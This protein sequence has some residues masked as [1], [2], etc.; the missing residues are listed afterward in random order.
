MSTEHLIDRPAYAGRCPSCRAAV[1]IA[2]DGGLDVTTEIIPASVNAEITAWL[3]RRYAW[4]IIRDPDTRQ[5]R[6]R[7]RGLARIKA[8]RSHP[9]V[10]A[11]EC[12]DGRRPVIP[13]AIPPP[14]P[15]PGKIPAV[16]D[17]APVPF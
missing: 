14:K 11:H 10:L 2:V 6:L 16:T 4:E 9:V 7:F 5:T 8:G 15:S 12:P 13:W 17:D 3:T 1:L